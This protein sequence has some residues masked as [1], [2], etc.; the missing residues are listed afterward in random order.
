MSI[1]IF[2]SQT[3][4]HTCIH[5]YMYIYTHTDTE[6]ILHTDM[7]KL[8]YKHFWYIFLS[9][10]AVCEKS[11][12]QRTLKHFSHSAGIFLDDDGT[13]IKILNFFCRICHLSSF[14]V[15]SDICCEQFHQI[16]QN[17]SKTSGISIVVLFAL[18]QNIYLYLIL[19]CSI[20]KVSFY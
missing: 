15:L 11:C 3:Y 6:A 20:P 4:L 14:C 1:K 7:H 5:T 19:I 17:K 13:T 8:L 16:H 2:P 18:I 12:S 10:S 9:V